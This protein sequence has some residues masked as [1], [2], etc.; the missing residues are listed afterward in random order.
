VGGVKKYGCCKSLVCVC[1]CFVLYNTGEIT[2]D[3]VMITVEDQPKRAAY[4][5]SRG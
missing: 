3:L 5:N 4:Y 1:M 2:L